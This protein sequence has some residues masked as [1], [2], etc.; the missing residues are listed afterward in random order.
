MLRGVSAFG[1]SFSQSRLCQRRYLVSSLMMLALVAVVLS[2]CSKKG[3][4]VTGPEAGD[5]NTTPA[6]EQISARFP[7]GKPFPN[8]EFTAIDGRR[9]ST[10]ALKGKVVL[11]D[12]WAT[13]CGPCTAQTPR[14]MQL[15]EQYHEKGF[16]I[17]GISLDDSA[18]QCAKYISDNKIPW[19]QY[20][21]GKGWD[22]AFAKRFNI[23]GIPLM[24]LIDREGNTVSDR[25]F[26]GQVVGKVQELMTGKSMAQVEAEIE[27]EVKA[28]V[29]ERQKA[30]DEM[31]GQVAAWLVA[32]E[33]GDARAQERLGRAYL[34][35]LGVPQDFDKARM[36]YRKAAEQGDAVA[37]VDLGDMYYLGEGVVADYNESFKWYSKAAE[38]NYPRGLRR[39]A[40]F[41]SRG[42]GAKE[43]ASRSVELDMKGAEA[44]D[45]PAQK[46]MGDRYITGRSVPKDP[47][48]AAEWY[49]KAFE[50]YAKRAEEGSTWALAE[51]GFGLFWGSGVE[52]DVERGLKLITKAAEQGNL[53]A[54]RELSSTYSDGRLV[55]VD[56][57][58]AV[59]WLMVAA[60]LGDM[61]SQ[62]HLGM[63]YYFGEVDL[64]VNHQ[65]AFEWLS[66]AADQGDA[67]AQ[68]RIAQMCAGGTGTQQDYVAA[69]MWLTISK[70]KMRMLNSG[71][72]T[73][74]SLAAKM[75]PEQ[76]AEAER[77]AA[78]FVPRRQP[79]EEEE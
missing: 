69:Y 38:Q 23:E 25:L 52:R 11:V 41:Y 59:K 27:A 43:D 10:A 7:A 64:P 26:G 33:K 66:K 45:P 76:I 54:Q 6:E 30:S 68:F 46:A 14:L 62:F 44:G 79:G 35:G 63:A 65:K 42:Y 51:E 18:W 60:T 77:R 48:K 19:P 13:W 49:H 72:E 32:A 70:R 55:A 15:Y 37:Q 56:Y 75:T 22:S 57:E 71:Q 53:R 39:L 31:K 29:E 50:S 16:E 3:K 20:Y 40:L 5:A 1:V 78:A 34:R 4:D 2:G 8:I 58:K 28:F 12:F 36:W 73:R 61:R 24:V 74:E 17:I 67:D 47:N 21:D 9:V